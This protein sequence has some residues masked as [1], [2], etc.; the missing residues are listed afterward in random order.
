MFWEA[1][2]IRVFA[3]YQIVLGWGTCK[4]YYETDELPKANPTP[5][6][7]RLKVT[8]GALFPTANQFSWVGIGII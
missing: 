2:K 3:I 1:S 7:I 8:S 4:Y 6:K 5:Q